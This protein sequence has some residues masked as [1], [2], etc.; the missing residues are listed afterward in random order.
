MATV[1]SKRYCEKLAVGL[2]RRDG[3]ILQFDNLH[4]CQTHVRT[5]FFYLFKDTNEIPKHLRDSRLPFI[6]LS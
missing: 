6:C 4:G 5:L 1:S 3:I 2:S